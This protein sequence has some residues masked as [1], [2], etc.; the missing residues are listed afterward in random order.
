MALDCVVCNNDNALDLNCH[1]HVCVKC[2]VD[3]FSSLETTK[4][5]VCRADIDMNEIIKLKPCARCQHLETDYCNL[6]E[7]FLCHQCWPLIHSFKPLTMHQKGTFDINVALRK[8]LFEKLSAGLLNLKDIDQDINKLKNESLNKTPSVRE[9]TLIEVRKVFYEYRNQLDQ[10]EQAIEAYIAEQTAIKLEHCLAQKIETK[11]YVDQCKSKLFEHSN[12]ELEI[13]EVDPYT[14]DLEYNLI[15]HELKLPEIIEIPNRETLITDPSGIQRWFLEGNLHR[16]GDLPAVIYPDG[17]REYY[18]YG[19]MHRDN[20]P[21]MITANGDQYW[22]HEGLQHRDVDLPAVICVGGGKIWYQYGK[23]HR[24]NDQPAYINHNGDQSWYQYGLIHR[25][26]ELPAQE[27][28]NGAKCY[29]V[30]GKYHR[31]NGPAQI[32]DK[33][34]QTWYQHGVVHQN[35]DQPAILHPDGLKEWYLNGKLYKRISATGDEQYYSNGVLHRD[36]D[37][38]AYILYNGMKYFY[39]N[40]KI[41]RDHDLPAVIYPDGRQDFYKDGILHRD[42]DQPAIIYPNGNKEYYIRGVKQNP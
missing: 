3:L 12:S 35:N 11:A 25:E 22:Y 19:R 20:G 16:T 26:N 2:I 9:R 10:Q 6:C 33:G 14:S 38:P 24:D 15:V 27:C 18:K 13:K 42:G 34:K 21:A 41:H 28:V 37:L 32:T 5:P 39:K 29:F 4:C 36:D 30:W 31:T 23:Y 1:H 40:G 7:N 8:S 17:K